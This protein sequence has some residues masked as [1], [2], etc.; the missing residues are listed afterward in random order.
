MEILKRE[1]QLNTARYCFSFIKGIGSHGGHSTK[2]FVTTVNNC[3]LA[4]ILSVVR[5]TIR[6]RHRKVLQFAEGSKPTHL[7]T[8]SAFPL[9]FIPQFLDF[10]L[11]HPLNFTTS[12]PFSICIQIHYLICIK[13]C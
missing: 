5:A 2:L 13:I 3:L 7:L 12:Q 8:I 6:D 9:L 11:N 10:F 1:R 4:V